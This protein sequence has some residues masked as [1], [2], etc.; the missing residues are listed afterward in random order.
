MTESDTEIHTLMARLQELT[1]ASPDAWS[2]VDLTFTQLRALFVLAQRPR[3]VSELAAAL[4][5]SVASAS[6]LSDRLVRL[7]LVGRGGDPNDRRAVLLEVAPLGTRLLRRLQ[8]GQ[9]ARLTRAVSQMTATERKALVTILRAF[10]RLAPTGRSADVR[11][12]SRPHT[13]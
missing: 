3:R 4:L 13:G 5:M 1:A 12:Q 7:G 10:V 2:K 8:W 11:A 9:T 6:A